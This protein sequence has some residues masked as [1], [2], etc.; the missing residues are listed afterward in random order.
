MMS[1]GELASLAYKQSLDISDQAVREHIFDA[2]KDFDSCS[3]VVL[4]VHVKDVEQHQAARV[5][6]IGQPIAAQSV[7]CETNPKPAS[8]GRSSIARYL[9]AWSSRLAQRDPKSAES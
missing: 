3:L 9:T 7:G 1:F 8:D 2:I 4:L 5:S 6:E